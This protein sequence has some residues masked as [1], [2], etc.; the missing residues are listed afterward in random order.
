MEGKTAR[1]ASSPAKPA[2][3]TKRTDKVNRKKES[4]PV[5]ITQST[6]NRIGIKHIEDHTTKQYSILIMMYELMIDSNIYVS[7]LNDVAFACVCQSA[8]QVSQ[9]ESA[10]GRYHV[11]ECMYVPCTYRNHYQLRVLEHHRQT[12]LDNRSGGE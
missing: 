11:S 8:S 1:G 12:C 3:V 10:T 6:E 4:E 2:Y 5:E 7:V 9:S